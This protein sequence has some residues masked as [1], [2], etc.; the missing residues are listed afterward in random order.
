LLS[1]PCE[2]QVSLTAPYSQTRSAYIPPSLWA[3]KFH[4]HKKNQTKL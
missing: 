3:T 2:P 4:T 1:R